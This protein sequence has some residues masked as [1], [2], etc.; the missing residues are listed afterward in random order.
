[1]ITVRQ[2]SS[3]AA[4]INSPT[5]ALV[6]ADGSIQL[7]PSGSTGKASSLD[8]W[9]SSISAVRVSSQPARLPSPIAY[10]ARTGL[11][12]GPSTS[13]STTRKPAAAAASMVPSPPSATGQHDT[14]DPGTCR[15]PAAT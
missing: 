6:A 11:P 12:S 15:T 2:L 10:R 9:A 13:A 1:M 7:W 8:A 5:P 3:S 4:V 14:S